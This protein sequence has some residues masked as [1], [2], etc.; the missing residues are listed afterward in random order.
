MV[1]QTTIVL[2]PV[3]LLLLLGIAAL[4]I[5][6]YN[7]Y[8]RKRINRILEDENAVVAPSPAPHIAWKVVLVLVFIVAF[9]VW[10]SNKNEEL[11]QL[12]QRCE[13]MSYVVNRTWDTV[14]R[15]D[16]RVQEMQTNFVSFDYETESLNVDDRTMVVRF[17]AVPKEEYLDPTVSLRYGGDTIPLIP[18]EDGVYTASVSMNPFQLPETYYA[19]LCLTEDGRTRTE[20]IYLHPYV[21]DY[22][23]KIEGLNVSDVSVQQNK[24]TLKLSGNLSVNFSNLYLLRNVHLLLKQHDQIIDD[25]D[26]TYEVVRLEK[27]YP[28][29][30]AIFFVL[31]WEDRYG[32][33]HE[34]VQNLI[35]LGG[36]EIILPY[37]DEL[38]FDGVDWCYRDIV[39]TADG[40]L[41][42][43][44]R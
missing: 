32:L 15:M 17:T 27:E 41:L 1:G 31:Q 5:W 29:N 11:R 7:R 42:G 28:N 40:T 43:E 19:T 18:D 10:E 6:L 35:D 24:T 14:R 37:G 20:D 4:A 16:A 22:F 13:S 2:G 9:C 23:P 3:V 26:L 30:A 8:Y 38:G 34:S 39:Y 12:Q 33:K 36:T 21:W 44:L 25:L